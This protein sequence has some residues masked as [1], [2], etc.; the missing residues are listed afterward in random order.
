MPLLALAHMAVLELAPPEVVSCA[1]AAGFSAVNLRLSPAREGEQQ[2]PMIG[3][4]P[5]M[6][7]TLAV[8]AD[9]GV[10]VSDVEVIRIDRET[11]PSSYAGVFEAA[12]KLGA[13]RIITV[14]VDPDLSCVADRFARI[15]EVAAP[16]GVALELEFMAFTEVKTLSQALQV[17]GQAGQP[18][19][20]ILVD[21][22]HVDRSGTP[23]DSIGDIDPQRVHFFQICD[24]PAKAPPPDRLSF[25]ARYDRLPPGEGGLPL[26]RIMK[27]LPSGI[28]V[29]VEVPL[30]G[31]R[32]KLPALERARILH[33]S[34]RRFLD[35]TG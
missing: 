4:T 19:S 33:D 7:D 30:G 3:D 28:D 23:V 5:M 14:G 10:K 20:G 16:Y 24:A 2:F 26:R 32:G 31:E 34:A 25:E 21:T 18:N 22:L 35:Q 11:D 17:V 8:L 1:A 13:R 12:Q 9:T 27:M 6:R 15:C 29:S